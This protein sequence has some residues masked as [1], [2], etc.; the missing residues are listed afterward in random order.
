MTWQIDDDLYVTRKTG[1]GIEQP[2]ERLE[3]NGNVK[4]TSFQGDGSNLTGVV[5]NLD[6]AVKKAGDTMTGALTIQNDLTVTGNVGIATTAAP[7]ERLEVNGNVKAT[8]FLGDGSNL[9]GVV[10]NLDLAVKKAGDTMTGA[11]TIQNNLTVTGKVGVTGNLSVTNILEIGDTPFTGNTGGNRDWMQ[12]GIK[13]NWD[14]DSLFVGLKDE[15]SNRKDAVIAWGDDPQDDLRFINVLAGGD[16][17]GKEL[18]RVKTSGNVGIGTPS[19]SATLTVDD[20]SGNTVWN[21]AAFRK[22]ALGPNWS[23]IHW[24]TTGDWYIRSAANA[25][26]VLIQDLGGNVGIGTNNP[27]QKLHIDGGHL[28][29]TNNGNT[30][31]IS[32][33]GNRVVFY[34]SNAYHGTNKRISWDGDNNWDQA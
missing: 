18:M 14:S 12:K 34:L 19:P 15:G 10:K 16:V 8:S 23:H 9:T 13:I 17:Q 5:K 29:I 32:V 25:G 22:A 21:T 27:Q 4:A 3:V 7:S 28:T 6:L 1:L 26:K 31:T 20:P 33:E 11:L 30:F 2:Q 24:G